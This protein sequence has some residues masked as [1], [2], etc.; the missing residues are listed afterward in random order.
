[1][2]SGSE[3][4]YCGA[5][6]VT[7]A[8]PAKLRGDDGW[9]RIAREHVSGCE[10]IE[11]RAHTREAIGVAEEFATRIRAMAAHLGLDLGDEAS[12]LS[13]VA[14]GLDGC[15]ADDTLDPADWAR[16]LAAE[17]AEGR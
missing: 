10:W 12:L 7:D 17:I 2:V 6:N 1:M 15:A 3:C 5:T 11:T 4:V 9:L 16:G 13:W 14:E 8:D